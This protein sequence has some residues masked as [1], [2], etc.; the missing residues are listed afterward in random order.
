MMVMRFFG[1]LSYALVTALIFAFPQT[2]SASQDSFSGYDDPIAKTLSV[3]LDT[4]K[5]QTTIG[6][7]A[8][9][10]AAYDSYQ[11]LLDKVYPLVLQHLD[12]A[13]RALVKQSQE[14]WVAWQSAEW[15]ALRGPWTDQQGTIFEIE[16]PSS[17]AL[18]VRD[19]IIELYVF[20]PGP[21]ES[22]SFLHPW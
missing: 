20:W 11:K 8:C 13:S 5:N 4:P 10:T 15:R 1:V 9:Y 18:A 21:S 16:I 22:R 6:L 12:P 17:R 7:S 19:R 3:C 2:A 14:R